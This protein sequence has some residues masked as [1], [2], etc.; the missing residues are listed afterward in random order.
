MLPNNVAEI[1]LNYLDAHD[2]FKHSIISRFNFKNGTIKKIDRQME[3]H[4]NQVV[5]GY[6][7]FKELCKKSAKEECL[8]TMTFLVQMNSLPTHKSHYQ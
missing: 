6:D 5:I 4:K 1:R 7:F 8:P 2:M 3:A